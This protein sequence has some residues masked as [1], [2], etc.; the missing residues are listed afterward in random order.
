MKVSMIQM[1]S[2]SDRAAN[3]QTAADLVGLAVKAERPDL[4]ILPEYFAFLGDSAMEMHDSSEEFPNGEVYSFLSRLA[5][6]HGITL[7]AGSIVEKEDNRFYNTTLVFGPDGGEIARYRKIHLFDVDT[8]NGINYRESD[9]VSRGQEIVTYRVGNATVGCAICYD[10]RF[11]ELF[12][13]L[14]DRDAEVIVLPA[15]FTLM[16]GKDHWEILARARAIETQTYFVAVAQTGT[17]ADGKKSCWGH[18]MIVDPW[19]N[20][21]AQSSDLI[22]VTTASMDFYYVNL[23][24]AN[25]P[26]AEHHVL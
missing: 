10:I 19:G 25:V 9:S 11:P 15:A 1:N 23:V 22:G 26:V 24:R 13:A 6:D 3:L 8:P 20:V 21:I 18:S 4:V 16:T 17:H 12:R 7:H 2:Q 14:R 5:A